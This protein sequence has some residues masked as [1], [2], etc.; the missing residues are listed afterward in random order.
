MGQCEGTP[1]DIR[2]EAIIEIKGSVEVSIG[3]AWFQETKKKGQGVM[4]ILLVIKV[5]AICAA[6]AWVIHCYED[7]DRGGAAS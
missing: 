6:A 4:W 7:R 1:R 3:E 5:F 2:G